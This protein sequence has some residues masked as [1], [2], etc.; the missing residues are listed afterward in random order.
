ME[1]GDETN[2]GNVKKK[3]PLTK[4][5]SENRGKPTIDTRTVF[6]LKFKKN[7]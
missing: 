5:S 7:I 3:D 2:E 1:G 6:V 4:G